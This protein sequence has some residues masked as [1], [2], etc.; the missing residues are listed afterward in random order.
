MGDVAADL[1][2]IGAVGGVVLRVAAELPQPRHPELADVEAILRRRRVSAVFGIPDAAGYS[3]KADRRE[4]VGTAERIIGKDAVERQRILP[5]HGQGAVSRRT[6]PD[7]T[8]A[9]VPLPCA[10]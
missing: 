5:E 9:I 2:L 8:H 6:D 3:L 1:Q 10:A 7:I 4:G